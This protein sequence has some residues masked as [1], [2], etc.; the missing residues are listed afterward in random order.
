[1]YKITKDAGIKI[2]EDQQAKIC[3][4]YKNTRLKILEGA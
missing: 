2:I 3:N 4:N 1:L